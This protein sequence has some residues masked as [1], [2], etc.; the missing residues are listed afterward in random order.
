MKYLS[1]PQLHWESRTLEDNRKS[2]TDLSDLFLQI[3]FVL[4]RYFTD[5]VEFEDWRF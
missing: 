3:L 1:G 5:S 2:A 4:W